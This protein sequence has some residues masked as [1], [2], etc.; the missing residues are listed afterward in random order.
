MIIVR[1]KVRIGFLE[2]GD[3][4]LKIGDVCLE[5]GVLLFEILDTT[6]QMVDRIKCVS[7]VS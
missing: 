5:I 3:E 4:C 7:D 6:I 2:I 1:Q